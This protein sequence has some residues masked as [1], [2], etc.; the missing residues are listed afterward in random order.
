MEFVDISHGFNGFK[1]VE[2]TNSMSFSLSNFY[3]NLVLQ[4]K[5]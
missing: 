2:W 3:L 4:D 5:A 1:S